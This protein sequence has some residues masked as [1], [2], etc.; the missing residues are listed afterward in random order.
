[1]ERAAAF[2]GRGVDGRAE[3]VVKIGGAE[4]DVDLRVAE[5]C[6]PRADAARPPGVPSR[7]SMQR[8]ST[9]LP[10]LKRCSISISLP[11]LSTNDERLKVI[12]PPASCSS[13]P[14]SNVSSPAVMHVETAERDVADVVGVD[15]H[16]AA[17][18]DDDVLERGVAD[19]P[20]VERGAAD[21]GRVHLEVARAA[22][23]A[24]RLV[25]AA[26]G[27]RDAGD[28]NVLGL[29]DA[30]AV[31]ARVKDRAARSD[32]PFDAGDRDLS[33]NAV[34]DDPFVERSRRDSLRGNRLE[35][36]LDAGVV[37]FE[38]RAVGGAQRRRAADDELRRLC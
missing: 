5:R 17:A 24:R 28:A 11:A 8:S 19:V 23:A 26:V 3:V 30:D 22:H 14:L 35:G 36:E 16:G 34:E 25:D 7:A 20:Q 6:E 21:G 27:E 4:L 33:V 9:I 38:R 29:S 31:A 18:V 2:G 32:L 1:M 15:A 37:H 12:V 13:T 10:L